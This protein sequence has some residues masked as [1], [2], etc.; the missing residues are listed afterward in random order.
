ML[1][2]LLWTFVNF[3]EGDT[4]ISESVLSDLLTKIKPIF[5]SKDANLISECLSI[6]SNISDRSYNHIKLLVSDKSILA[7]LLKY[8][9]DTSY[10]LAFP[11]V[12]ALGNIAAGTCDQVQIILD[13]E[14]LDVLSFQ[15]E[16]TSNL[17]MKKYIL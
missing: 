1:K 13:K 4:I 16:K 14:V 17:K 15:Y 11:A 9:G 2:T 6:I 5:K 8:A 12:R 3:V 7:C 10:K